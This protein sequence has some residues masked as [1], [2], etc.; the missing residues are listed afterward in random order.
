MHRK[1]FVTSFFIMLAV[2][3]CSIFS[4]SAIADQ[5]LLY[6][7][8][9]AEKKWDE[10]QI[11]TLTIKDDATASP[12]LIENS[13]LFL[14]IQSSKTKWFLYVE[15]DQ[16]EWNEN[17]VQTLIKEHPDLAKFFPNPLAPNGNVI[18][19]AKSTATTTVR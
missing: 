2:L 15:V 5:S 4:A 9:K 18:W 11:K 8:V 3:M 6:Q 12:Y 16:P 10:S 14:I 19:I 1:N 13:E 7:S 17:K